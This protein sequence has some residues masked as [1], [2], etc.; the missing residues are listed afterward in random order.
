MRGIPVKA[1]S[2]MTMERIAALWGNLLT[3]KEDIELPKDME[4]AYLLIQTGNIKEIHELI[5]FD[6][7]LK[8]YSLRIKEVVVD[9][10]SLEAECQVSKNEEDCWK[11]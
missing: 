6:F 5:D 1:W 10:D 4:I 2:R 7:E 11:N 9:V 8:L 3:L